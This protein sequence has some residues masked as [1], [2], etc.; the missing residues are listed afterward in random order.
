ML[1]KVDLTKKI[2]KAEYRKIMKDLTIK[3]GELQRQ[4]RHM[5]IPITLVF[6]GWGAAGKG[7]LLNEFIQA[8]DPRGFSVYPMD[9]NLACGIK[10][11]M[12][13]RAYNG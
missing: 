6:E 3:L 7:V 4:A 9:D 10:R 1:E 8:L 11:A 12:R 2:A 5:N 13:R